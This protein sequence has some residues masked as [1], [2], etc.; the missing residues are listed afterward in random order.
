MKLTL[1]L[2]VVGLLTG[3]PST[4]QGAEHAAFPR[5]VSVCVAIANPQAFDGKYLLFDAV[6]RVEPHGA[7]LTGQTCPQSVVLLTKTADFSENPGAKTSF[8]SLQDKDEAKPIDVVYGG[9]FRVL[10]GFRCS[11]VHCFRFELDASK[12]I[13]VRPVLRAGR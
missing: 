3:P 8:D 2:V 11:E 9:T 7:V 10:H 13:A 12:L 4:A 1:S 5:A 6:Y